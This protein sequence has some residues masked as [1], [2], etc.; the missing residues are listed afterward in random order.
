MVAAQTHERDAAAA[1]P[2]AGVTLTDLFAS[3]AQMNPQAIALSQAAGIGQPRRTLTYEQT[4]R[5]IQR[6]MDHLLDLGLRPGEIVLVSMAATVEAPVAIL[7]A[8]RAG[9]TPCLV[10]VT[11]SLDEAAAVV[12]AVPARAIVTTGAIG[13]LRPVEILRAAAATSG[14]PRFVLAFGERLPAGV[15]PLDDVLIRSADTGFEPVDAGLPQRPPAV[16]TIERGGSRILVHRHEQSNLVA[17]SL[18]TVLRSGMASA[19][20]VLSTL[21]LMSLAG[22]TTG[23]GPCLLTA[24]T[25]AL[26]PLFSTGSFLASLSAH[27]RLHVVVPGALEGPLVE[28]GLSASVAIASTVLLH[29]QPARLDRVPGMPAARFPV[30]DALAIGERTVLVEIRGEDRRPALQL[31]EIRIPDEIGAVVVAARRNERGTLDVG[32]VTVSTRL[33]ETMRSDPEA[34]VETGSIVTADESQRILS[35]R[36]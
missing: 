32:G 7:A 35:I 14:G 22:L 33:D 36:N 1:M 9:F 26:E 16:L 13:P 6:T 15:I 27:P 31:G 30:I 24:G 10:P 21:S 4:D 5:A 3:T 18:L 12:S 23:L 20:P 11:V 34:Y 2:W 25:L 19:E 8:L 28:A 17:A 29:R